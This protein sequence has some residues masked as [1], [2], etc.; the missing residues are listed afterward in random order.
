MS[1]TVEHRELVVEDLWPFAHTP[2]DI[3]SL[4]VCWLAAWIHILV[5]TEKL[6]AVNIIVH[7]LDTLLSRDTCDE[8]S[9]ERK[10]QWRVVELQWEGRR[11]R[12]RIV[13]CAGRPEKVP[14]PL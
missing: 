6:Q 10:G 5:S 1:L 3:E 7:A 8:I 11:N 12:N 14:P 2:A 4:L 9:I 13:S